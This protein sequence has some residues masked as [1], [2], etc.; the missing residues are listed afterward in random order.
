MMMSVLVKDAVST[1]PT[2]LLGM[3]GKASLDAFL[4]AD[5]TLLAGVSQQNVQAL[6]DAVAKAASRGHLSFFCTRWHYHR[7][8]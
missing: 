5:D 6:L 2:D 4:Y 3:I 1:L 7:T 8:N